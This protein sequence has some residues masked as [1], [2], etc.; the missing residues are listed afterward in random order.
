MI[1]LF[2]L[3]SQEPAFSFVDFCYSCPC[4]FFIYFC[5]NFYDFFPLTNLGFFVSSLSSC[6]WCKVRLFIWF[7]SCFL[8][9]PCIAM[10][11]PLSSY[12]IESCRFWVVVFSFSFISVHILVSVLIY[13]VICWLFRSLL[14]SLHMFILLI[15]FPYSWH[16]ILPHH[17]QKRYLKLFHFFLN[18]PRL[19]WWPR[20]WSILEN[21]PCALEKRLKFIV[22]GEMSYIYQLGLT[23]PLYHLKFVFPW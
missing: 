4:F 18:L 3:S 5:P 21:V 16:L 14:L 23:G 19:D 22:W 13:S 10:N 8:R 7:F 11:L 6:F 2:Y 9:L 12:F 20:V 1:C 15:F 17:D